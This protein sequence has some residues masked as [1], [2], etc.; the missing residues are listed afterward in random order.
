MKELPKDF[1]LSLSSGHNKDVNF[2]IRTLYYKDKIIYQSTSKAERVV[3]NDKIEKYIK[4][5]NKNGNSEI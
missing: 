4:I 2:Y 3:W 1:S 5:I